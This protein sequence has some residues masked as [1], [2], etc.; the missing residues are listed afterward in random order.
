MTGQIG[1]FLQKDSE[2]TI[3]KK[4]KGKQILFQVLQ[5]LDKLNF[6]KK[7]DVEKLTMKHLNNLNL[8]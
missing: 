3:F 4:T 7:R 1:A 8:L 6:S 2:L 5:E